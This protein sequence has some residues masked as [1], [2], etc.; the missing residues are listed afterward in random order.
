MNQN[1]RLVIVLLALLSVLVT[2]STPMMIFMHYLTLAEVYARIYPEIAYPVAG[3]L[4]SLGLYLLLEHYFTRR[5]S[6]FRFWV[7][8]EK[9]LKEYNGFYEGEGKPNPVIVKEVLNETD[10]D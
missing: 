2:F 6:K 3:I 5:V 8:D 10:N 9:Y 4:W 7:L 1:T